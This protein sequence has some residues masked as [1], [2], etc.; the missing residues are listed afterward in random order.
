MAISNTFS[1]PTAG[2]S[3]TLSLIDFNRNFLAIWS[4]FYGPSVPTSGNITI[5]GTVSNPYE[6]MLW[7]SSTLKALYIYDPTNTKGGNP[8]AG[9][10]RVGVGHRNFESISSL[11]T[12]LG[13]IEQSEL[14]TTVGEST[15][16]YRVYMKT[17]NSNNIVD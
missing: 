14:L 10:T 3:F 11:V 12:G 2:K 7:R 4:N 13:G 1:I 16:N 17:N 5:E 8:G 6:G 9:F 15:A